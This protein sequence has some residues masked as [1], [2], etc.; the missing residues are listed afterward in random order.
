LRFALRSRSSAFAARS[1]RIAPA[2]SSTEPACSACFAIASASGSHAIVERRDLARGRDQ[3]VA[4]H[5][6]V[7]E[8]D[9]ERLGR[10]DD[11]RGEHELHRVSHPD[12]RGKR[13][14]LPRPGRM[15]SFVN[16]TPSF[17]RSD[18]IRM[19]QGRI[20]VTP[21]PTA[22]PFTA[23]ITGFGN[24]SSSSGRS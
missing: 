15:P 11:A 1:L 16:G 2:R 12:Q 4:R 5:D 23:A 18:A 22:A 19:S 9:R 10:L 24:A 7:H 14:E 6:A 8:P 13:C 20:I 17:A 21:T 3:R